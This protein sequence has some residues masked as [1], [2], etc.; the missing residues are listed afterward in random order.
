M[1]EIF[2]ITYGDKATEFREYRDTFRE[3]RWRF[4][5]NAMIDIALN[6]IDHLD[7]DDWVGVVSWKFTRKTGIHKER[8]WKLLESLDPS[9]DVVNCCPDIRHLHFMDW[10]EAGH[11]G[12]VRY[13]RSCCAHVGLEYNHDCA[14]VIFANQFVCRKSIYVDYVLNVI[15]PCLEL[16]EGE[17]WQEVNRPSGY[18]AGMHPERLLHLTGLTFYN[19]VPFIL[20]RM[21]MQYV[22]SND[23]KVVRA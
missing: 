3:K 6:H 7:S 19:Y 11:T 5:N 9:I 10:S 23:L 20:E 1:I 18:T 8:L 13:I 4:E 15:I 14:H 21:F 17:L 16:L 22:D 2:G 12:I